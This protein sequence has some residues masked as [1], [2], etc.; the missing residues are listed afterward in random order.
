MII[1]HEPFAERLRVI[2]TKRQFTQQQMTAILGRTCIRTVQDWLS[3]RR[4]PHRDMQ[5]LVLLKLLKS[6]A[7]RGKQA[8]SAGA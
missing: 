4:V 6:R 1:P 3:G 8:A 7:N 5:S 2:K